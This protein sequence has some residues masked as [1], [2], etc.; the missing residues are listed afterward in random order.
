MRNTRPLRAGSPF[1][2]AAVLNGGA[3]TIPGNRGPFRV[4]A[5]DA[6]R[7]FAFSRIARF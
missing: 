1:A 7:S 5:A 3:S 4:V 2:I 6:F